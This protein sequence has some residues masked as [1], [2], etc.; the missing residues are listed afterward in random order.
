MTIGCVRWDVRLGALTDE[1]ARDTRGLRKG[2]LVVAQKMFSFRSQ[3]KGGV[4]PIA[5]LMLVIQCR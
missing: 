1:Q 5:E 3:N 4:L 2:L